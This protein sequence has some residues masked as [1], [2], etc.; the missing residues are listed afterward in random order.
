LWERYEYRVTCPL[1]KEVC[2]SDQT[3][4]IPNLNPN[5]TFGIEK[6]LLDLEDEFISRFLIEI[7]THRPSAPNTFIA[8]MSV[9]SAAW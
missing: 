8:F 9:S 3:S 4:I 2:Y 5:I 6:T 7:F 1:L